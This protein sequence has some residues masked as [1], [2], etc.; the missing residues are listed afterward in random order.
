V[1]PNVVTLECC[2]ILYN[3]FIHIHLLYTRIYISTLYLHIYIIYLRIY[4]ST[5]YLHIYISTHLYTYIITIYLHIYNV[6]SA[7]LYIYTSTSTNL[8]ADPTVAQEH[9]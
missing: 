3:V 2:F 5:L 6:M 7:Y 9:E 1:S 8:V 4:I